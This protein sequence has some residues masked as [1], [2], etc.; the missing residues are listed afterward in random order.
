MGAKESWGYRGGR[1][2]GEGEC[3]G[4]ESLKSSSGSGFN[5]ASLSAEK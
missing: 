2:V 3:E 4:L 5:S 1:G